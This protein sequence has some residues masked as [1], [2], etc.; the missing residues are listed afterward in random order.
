[1]TAPRY[2]VTLFTPEDLFFCSVIHAG[3]FELER[4]GLIRLRF[5]LNLEYS[6]PGVFISA[7]RVRDR[8]SGREAS[9]AADMKDAPDGFIPASYRDVDRLFKRNF[10]PGIIAAAVPAGFRDKILPAGLAYQVRSSHDHHRWL[11]YTAA[12]LHT[13]KHMRQSGVR[14]LRHDLLAPLGHAYLWKMRRHWRTPP[15]AFYERNTRAT[16]EALVYF[17]TRAFDPDP[18]LANHLDQVV[19]SKLEVNRSRIALILALRSALGPAFRGGLVADPFARA[20][21]PEVLSTLPSAQAVHLE[22]VERA[23]VVV[24]SNGLC[25]SPAFKLAEFLAA[26]KCIVAERLACELPAPLRDGEHLVWFD[27]PEEC[28]AHCR[29]LLAD[30]QRCRRLGAAARRYYDTHVAP[31]RSALRMIET[32]LAAGCGARAGHVPA[33]HSPPPSAEGAR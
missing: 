29:A 30:P 7:Y 17:Q 31:H 6:Q 21:H 11:L 19:A 22:M 25:G 2:D 23:Q 15:V 26:G 13:L 24:Y 9:F 14:R 10:Q 12:C 32:S 3:L 8:V 1:M 5:R 28:A 33:P 27:H 20:H 16:P 4:A 18:R